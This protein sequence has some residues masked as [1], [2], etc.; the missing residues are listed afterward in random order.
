MALAPALGPIGRTRTSLVTAVHRADA[1]TVHD[2]A[3]PINLV[4]AREPIQRKVDQIPHAR[5]L[6][7]PQATPARHPRSAPE[8]LREHLPRNT[9]T[10]DENNPCQ[11]RAFREARPTTL[12]PS[13]RNRQERVDKIP[14]RIW[15]QR[16]GHA[17]SHYLAER[18]MCRGFVT[19]SK[20]E[21]QLPLVPSTFYL[22]L[23]PF[24]FYL[25]TLSP[26]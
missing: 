14:Q 13:W 8:F 9:A 4:I 25:L 18:I 2:R 6:P 21:R 11:A 24:T 16:S 23:L 22:C 17:C 3:R 12:S 15:K 19:R 20:G 7:V 10:K 5:L 26:L 1:T